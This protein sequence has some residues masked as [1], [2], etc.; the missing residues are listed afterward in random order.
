[1]IA[2]DDHA[3]VVNSIVKPGA[4]FHEPIGERS[5][6]VGGGAAVH[7]PHCQ[8]RDVGVHSREFGEQFSVGADHEWVWCRRR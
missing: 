2:V 5:L 1:V 3:G 7:D 6:F 8:W 4:E